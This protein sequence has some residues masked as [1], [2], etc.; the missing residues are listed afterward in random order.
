MS[1]A[2]RSTR[3]LD[4]KPKA[5]VTTGLR[6]PFAFAFMERITGE[7]DAKSNQ[8]RAFQDGESTPWLNARTDSYEKYVNSVFAY[9]IRQNEDLVEEA[10]KL[11]TEL[12]I[13]LVAENNIIIG[14]DEEA[15][16]QRRLESERQVSRETRKKE[17]LVRLAEIK[18]FIEN[19]DEKLSHHIEMAK[20][21]L[22]VH[23]GSYWRGILKASGDEVKGIAPA[24]TFE[25]YKGRIKYQFRKDALISQ[26]DR[27][28]E[29][30][31][32]YEETEENE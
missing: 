27:A 32:C 2:T 16:R 8:V 9:V 1:K 28:L 30:G 21:V 6:F 23:T 19:T 17:I 18:A 14:E 5:G 20:D 25:E 24:L 4:R 22:S 11:I 12:N 26:I 13:L 7:R 10:A 31:G 29:K 3:K 15:I